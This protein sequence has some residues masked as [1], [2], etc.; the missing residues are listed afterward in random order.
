MNPSKRNNTR[1][2]KMQGSHRD[3]MEKFAGKQKDNSKRGDNK[4][5][6]QMRDQRRQRHPDAE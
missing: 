1:K 6:R 2:Y 3:M 4:A 5:S